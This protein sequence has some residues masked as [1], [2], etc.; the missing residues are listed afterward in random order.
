[1]DLI[2]YLVKC[3]THLVFGNSAII[4]GFLFGYPNAAKY[5]AKAYNL[6]KISTQELYHLAMFTNNA[7]PAFILITVGLIMFENLKVG[8]ILLISHILSSV[9]LGIIFRPKSIIQQDLKNENSNCFKKQSLFNN[10]VASIL[11]TFKTLAIIFSF[12]VIFNILSTF[13][14]TL[15]SNNIYKLIVTGIFEISNGLNIT[16]ASAMSLNAKILISSLILG[17]S[18]LMI[19]FQVY[20]S[21]LTCPIKLRCIFVAKVLQGV[22]SCRNYIS[23]NEMGIL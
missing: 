2:R 1:M 4:I 11:D 12:T 19:M 23:I 14:C 20:S 13:M 8:I 15:S 6:R 3:F 9:I 10:I 16:A 22:I 17:F 21:F 18:S 5:I 7:N